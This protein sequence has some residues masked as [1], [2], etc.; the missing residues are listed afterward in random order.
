MDCWCF[1]LTILPQFFSLNLHLFD[2]RI[3]NESVHLA[4]SSV[5]NLKT[6][7]KC[8]STILHMVQCMEMQMLFIFYLILICLKKDITYFRYRMDL[9]GPDGKNS[10]TSLHESDLLDRQ[11]SLVFMVVY[12]KQKGNI[13]SI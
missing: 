2:R 13:V 9:S 11:P 1:H 7:E 4:T 5:D 12:L 10:E 6:L 3:S 8:L